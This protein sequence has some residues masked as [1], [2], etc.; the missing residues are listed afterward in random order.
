MLLLAPTLFLSM[1]QPTVAGGQT[2]VGSQGFALLMPQPAA[3][4]EPKQPLLRW[5]YMVGTSVPNELEQHPEDF[6]YLSPAWFHLDDAGDI[7]GSGSPEVE[8]FAISHHIKLVPIV[9][10]GEFDAD[11]AHDML[12]DGTLQTHVLDSLQHLLD[13]PAY[14]G[15]NIDFENLYNND[16]GAFSAFMTNV[17]ARLHPLG[18]QVTI[19]L[20]AKTAEEADGFATPFDYAGL[21]PNFDLAVVMTYDYHYAGGPAGA[22]SPLSWVDDVINYATR[23]IPPSKL[24]VGLPFYGYD[25]DVTAGGWASPAEYSDIQQTVF[26]HGGQIKMVPSTQTPVYR[27]D[28]EDGDQHEIWFENS[29][30]LG[31]KINLAEQHGLAGW[32]AWRLGQEDQNFWSLNL[33]GQA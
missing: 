17:Y 4:R 28:D 19:A 33:S 7:Y 22:V 29:T 20:P 10:N 6:D 15:I 30:S 25:W 21:A 1:A 3:P 11:V 16:R 5:A 24:L 13:N 14:A 32:G 8:A 23:Y 27:Y 31:Y 18:K 2:A 9:A 12:I 26:D